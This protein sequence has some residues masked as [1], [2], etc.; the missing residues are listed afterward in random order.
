W[1]RYLDVEPRCAVDGCMRRGRAVPRAL[2]RWFHLRLRISNCLRYEKAPIDLSLC[3]VPGLVRGGAI[4][5]SNP[6]RGT[7]VTQSGQ[8]TS[9]VVDG[10]RERAN[11]AC[12]RH[13]R[14]RVHHESICWANFDVDAGAS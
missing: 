9:E 6:Q 3:S 5:A 11:G 8:R 2:I 14:A 13:V 7:Q 1:G 4:G 10:P 12:S